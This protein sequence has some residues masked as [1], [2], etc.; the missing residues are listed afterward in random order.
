MTENIVETTYEWKDIGVIE[1]NTGKIIFVD[2]ANVLTDRELGEIREKEKM[3]KFSLHTDFKHG[4][5]AKTGFGEGRYHAF[6]KVGTF[7]NLEKKITEIRVIFDYPTSE[8]VFQKTESVSIRE[9][10]DN[11]PEKRDNLS[12]GVKL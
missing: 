5:V 7:E 4:I 8:N 9:S 2:P 11:A 10:I 6:A 12:K 1:V 3:A